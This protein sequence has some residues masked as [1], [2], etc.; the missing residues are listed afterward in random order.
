MT[1][2]KNTPPAATPA[3]SPKEGMTSDVPF[4]PAQT[5]EPSATAKQVS[6]EEQEAKD[7]ARFNELKAQ[8]LEDPAIK[9]LRD[10]ADSL[11]GQAGKDAQRAYYK[12][13]FDKVRATDPSI[14]DYVGRLEKFAMKRFEGDN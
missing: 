2:P 7:K 14:S 8:A 1:G 6:I 12:A 9:A 10:K 11:V 3:P 5:P 4:V 13:L